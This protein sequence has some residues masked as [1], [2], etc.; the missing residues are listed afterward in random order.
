MPE[1]A[2]DKYGHMGGRK[3][4]ISGEALIRQWPTGHPVA[5]A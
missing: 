5:E 1:A 2:I 4:K 3:D